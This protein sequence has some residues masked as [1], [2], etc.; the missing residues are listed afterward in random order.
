[1]GVGSS[2][3]VASCLGGDG[4]RT[5]RVPL[6]RLCNHLLLLPQLWLF[7]DPFL[8]MFFVSNLNIFGLEDLE[9]PT[10]ANS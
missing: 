1:M 9:K 10:L 7:R 2:N 8:F 4:D 3:T 5:P 6:L